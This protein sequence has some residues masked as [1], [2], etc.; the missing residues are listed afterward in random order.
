MD[1][2]YQSSVD[3][4]GASAPV[5]LQSVGMCISRHSGVPRHN[6]VCVDTELVEGGFNLNPYRAGFE[7]FFSFAKSTFDKLTGK[8][9]L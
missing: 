5:I 1:Q 6:Q 4:L 8:G 3:W 2:S 7:A 9:F